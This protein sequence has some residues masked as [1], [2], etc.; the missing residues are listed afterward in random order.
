MALASRRTRFQIT[1][2]SKSLK[3][4]RFTLKNLWADITILKTSLA[5]TAADAVF[6]TGCDKDQIASPAS[7][8]VTLVVKQSCSS[9]QIAIEWVQLRPRNLPVRHLAKKKQHS[10]ATKEALR[11]ATFPQLDI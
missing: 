9:Q 8:K 3:R 11:L 7:S 1:N 6:E 2:R 5:R 4:D 10:F